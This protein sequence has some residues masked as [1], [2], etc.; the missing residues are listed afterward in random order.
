[1]FSIW[2][3]PKCCCVEWFTEKGKTMA[4]S[5]FPIFTMFS[6]R[7]FSWDHLKLRQCGKN[8]LFTSPQNFAIILVECILEQQTECA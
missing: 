2:S 8:Q 7:L 1:M 3:D 6:K 5:I 4:N